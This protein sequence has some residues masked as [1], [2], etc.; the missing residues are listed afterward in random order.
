M[1]W[2][3]IGATCLA[4][5][6]GAS[7]GCGGGTPVTLTG[8]LNVMGVE[9]VGSAPSRKTVDGV[10]GVTGWEGGGQFFFE[11]YLG[12]EKGQSKALAKG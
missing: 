7:A 11:K 9:K 10:S 1:W 3:C 5:T 12:L 2:M 4:R 6:L 8:G